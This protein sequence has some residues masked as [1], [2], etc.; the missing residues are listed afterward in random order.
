MRR[1]INPNKQQTAMPSWLW[2]AA[3]MLFA[4]GACEKEE[5][6]IVDLNQNQIRYVVADNFNLSL[7]DGAIR[8]AGLDNKLVEPGP[9]TLLAPTDAAFNELGISTPEGLA[10]YDR[11]R[12]G[13]IAAYHVLDG[14]YDL[15]HTPFVFNQEARSITGGKLFVS[16]WIKGGDT[17]LTVNG[18]LVNPLK[19]EASNGLVQVV[20]RL[21]EPYLHEQITDAIAAE[22]DLTIFYEAMKRT[23]VLADFGRDGNYTVYAPDN[24]AMRAAGYGGVTAIAEAD[25]AQL[26]NFVNYHI[27]GIR[28]FAHDYFLTASADQTEV[29]QLMR[30]GSET[31]ITL[32]PD[33]ENPNLFMGLSIRGTNN[34][35]DANFLRRDI[36]TGN[37]VLHVIDQVLTD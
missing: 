23:G 4:F 3:L 8:L 6:N 1:Q 22:A 31:I 9:F 2:T 30:N 5:A 18:A 25:P 20:D 28:R 10:G 37:G 17:L 16:R 35:W 24:S 33:W 14:R 27:A 34:A 29:R 13:Q 7:Y 11:K 15:D 12:L 21:L 36:L 19:L 26:R 32:F